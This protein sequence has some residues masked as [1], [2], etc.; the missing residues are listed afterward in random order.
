MSSNIKMFHE[1]LYQTFAENFTCLSSE[2]PKKILQTG[3]IPLKLLGKN[4]HKNI[5]KI[6]IK[7]NLS[8][9]EAVCLMEGS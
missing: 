3:P 8:V 1:K 2:K 4:V 7:N 6:T 5:L 9:P